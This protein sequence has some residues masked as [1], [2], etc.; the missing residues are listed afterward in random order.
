[1]EN[2]LL[3]KQLTAL[4]I[5]G[6]TIKTIMESMFAVR[7]VCKNIF[8]HFDIMQGMNPSDLRGMEKFEVIDFPRA[9]LS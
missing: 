9:E 7:A 6:M 2:N 8:K 4:G 5:D 3:G 1:M